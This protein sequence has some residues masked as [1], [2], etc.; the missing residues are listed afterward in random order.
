MLPRPAPPPPPAR[1]PAPGA[2]P[3]R[4]PGAAPGAGGAAP[5]ARGAGAPPAPG[6]APPPGAVRATGGPSAITTTPCDA[7]SLRNSGNCRPSL[8][9]PPSPHTITGCLDAPSVAGR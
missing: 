4:G 2:P 9:Q 5:P 8:A 7:I 6:A 1:G 3:A